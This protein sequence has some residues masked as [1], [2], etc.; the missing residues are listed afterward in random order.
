[1]SHTQLVDIP[2]SEQFPADEV[3]AYPVSL[4]RVIRSE[5]IKFRTLRSSWA[6]LA[7]AIAGMI[8][9]GLIVAYNTRRLSPGLQPDD[10]TVSATLQGYYLG[11]LLVGAL[12]VLFVSGEYS[13]GMIRSTFAA[14]PARTPVL[15]AKAIVFTVAAAVTMIVVSVVAFLAAQALI[16]HYRTG[17]SLSDPGALRVVLGT[18]I[19]L[20]TVGLIGGALAWI[21]R[22]TPGS[23]VAY[24]ALV[25]VLPV[26][27]GNVL[28]TWG[29]D[30]AQ[31]LP[32]EAGRSFVSGMREPHT[33]G[34]WTG[35]AVLLAW[36][37]ALGL[38]A[39][40]QLRR[41]DA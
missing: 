22:S 23:L 25:L 13:T 29:K 33:L 4:R 15:L 7:A 19:Y 36:T 35:L 38:I 32:S 11:Q 28:G 10:L 26:L 1:M 5:T 39:A 8:V 41:R 37:I 31:Y 6:V 18:G 17:Y 20:T 12:G 40:V 24:F 21:V 9:I 3:A 16:G 27:F 2:A 34:P 14:V 30:I